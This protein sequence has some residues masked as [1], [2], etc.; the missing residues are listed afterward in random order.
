MPAWD[1]WVQ[2]RNGRW[3]QEHAILDLR[4]EAPPGVPVTY[5]DVVVARPCSGTY[6]GGAATV[7]GYAARQAEGPR[8]TP[9]STAGS[10]LFR[11]RPTVG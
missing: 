10:W 7:D 3:E 5:L 8:P 2:R 6:V 9:G 11:S 4:L 1:R